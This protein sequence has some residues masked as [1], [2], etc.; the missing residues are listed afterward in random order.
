MSRSEPGLLPPMKKRKPMKPHLLVGKLYR[1]G[2]YT[3]YRFGTCHGLFQMVDGFFHVYAVMNTDPNNGHFLA[4]MDRLER[5]YDVRVDA[6]IF[7]DALRAHLIQK[8][9]YTPV[10]AFDDRVEKRRTPCPT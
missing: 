8:R 5:F 4:L 6:F 3:Q 2:P 9:G 1:D 7:G 10:P